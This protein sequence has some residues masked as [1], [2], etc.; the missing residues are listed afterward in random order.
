M[1]RIHLNLTLGAFHAIA[2]AAGI[3]AAFLVE[4]FRHAFSDIAALAKA[5]GQDIA[6]ALHGDRS[7]RAMHA[8]L[9]RQRDQL[10]DAAQAVKGAVRGAMTRAYVGEATQA[11]AARIAPAKTAANGLFGQGPLPSKP[12]PDKGL[13]AAQR[14]LAQA[15]A[16]ATFKRIKDGLER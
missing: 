13:A 11:I 15:E 5:L 1:I 7:M 4:R 6:A 10:K 9:A 2:S 16:E 8:V 3:M 14:E 12:V